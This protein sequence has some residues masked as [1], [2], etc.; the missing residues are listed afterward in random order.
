MSKYIDGFL[1]PI[2]PD[3]LG[4]YQ[5][6]ATLASQIWKEHG[7]LEYIE[8]AGDD[9]KA[10]IPDGKSPTELAGAKEGE[11]LI[12]A[13]IVYQSREHRDTV[14]AKVMAD[15]RMKEICPGQNPELSIPF[16]VKRM[17]TGGFKVIVEA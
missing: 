16:D 15:P 1:I 8:A 11:T 6:I 3:K 10:C 7:A 4:E 17:I 13:Y 12:F 5:R 9:L 14:N 2:H